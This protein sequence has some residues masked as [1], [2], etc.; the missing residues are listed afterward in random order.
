M[1][2]RGEDLTEC[3]SER[4]LTEWAGVVVGSNEHDNNL[5]LE[6]SAKPTQPT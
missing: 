1:K 2:K 3:T 4:E 5:L 6:V